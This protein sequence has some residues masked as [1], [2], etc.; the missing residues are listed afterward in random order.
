MRHL[1]LGDVHGCF[2]SLTALADFVPLRPEDNLITLGDYIDRGPNSRAVLD[3]L[4]D[5]S[6]R[7]KLVALRG[8][9]E[10]MMLRA[11]ESEEELGR[12]LECGGDATL[13]SYSV[14]DDEGKLVDVPDSHWEFLEHGTRGW[15]ETERHF[16]VHA[17]AY[18]DCPLGEQPDF[19]LYWEPFAEGSPH[20]SGKVMVRAHAAK[21]GQAEERRPRRLHRH[22]GVQGGLADG[23]ERE[24]GEV[25]AGQRGG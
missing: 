5:Y 10:I 11:R 21:V 15:F 14:L 22:G 20:E 7:G 23:P 9:H 24:F 3:W 6:R 25:L 2:R 13:R 16:F 8:N 12:W 1:A 17:N 18:P 19:M 4:I